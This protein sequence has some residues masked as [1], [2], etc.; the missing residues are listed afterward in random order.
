MVAKLENKSK[1]SS[2]LHPLLA[3]FAERADE[4]DSYK[5]GVSGIDLTA[6]Y[7][8]FVYRLEPSTY[9]G[10][11]EFLRTF[12]EVP[13]EKTLKNLFGGGKYQLRIFQDGRIQPGSANLRIAGQP[14][15]SVGAD[16]SAPEGESV[17]SGSSEGVLFGILERK[18]QGLEEKLEDLLR[19]AHSA[20]GGGDS[21]SPERL[22]RLIDVAN[23]KRLETRLLESSLGVSA[24]DPVSVAPVSTPAPSTDMLDMVLKVFRTG[25]EFARGS[26]GGDTDDLVSKGLSHLL[27]LFGK[28]AGK[29]PV[30]PAVEPPRVS[31][32]PDV[33]AV[34]SL[35]A[36]Q[37]EAQRRAVERAATE[38][39]EVDMVERLQ[40]AIGVMLDAFSS[41][42]TYDVDDVA[43]F[44]RGVLSQSEIDRVGDKLTFDNVRQLMSGNPE[45]Q[46][47]LDTYKD[48]VENVLSL[49]RAPEGGTSVS[50][51]SD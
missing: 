16:A 28:A 45:S 18:M 7:Q 1:S 13:D 31:V 42:S 9:T 36:E 3:R 40:R 47:E 34:S 23:A 33:P 30:A 14:K 25:V 26:E 32:S 22:G 41:D 21:L 35:D 6:A 49:L 8:C 5:M 48:G 4:I 43:A 15:E 38:R 44:V 20:S 27:D 12:S 46:I 39:K 37:I 24:P 17:V 50:N 51:G 29:A 11:A 10:G 2:G 19:S